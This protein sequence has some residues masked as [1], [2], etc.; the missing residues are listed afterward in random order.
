[1]TMTKHQPFIWL[2]LCL[3]LTTLACSL[4]PAGDSPSTGDNRPVLGEDRPAIVF[5]A[6]QMGNKY[7]AGSQILLHAE[8]RDLGAGVARIEFYDNFDTLIETVTAE[9]PAGQPV[10]TAIVP[11]QSTMSQVHFLK[12]RAFRADGTQSNLQEISIEIVALESFAAS[13][14]TA[15]PAVTEVATADSTSAE[16][17][18]PEPAASAETPAVSGDPL[19]VRLNATVNGA[20]TLN[21]RSGAAVSASVLQTVRR[22]AQL[23]LVGRS[24]DNQWYATPLANGSY[25]WV[26]GQY[27]QIEGDPTTLPL[28]TSQ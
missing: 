12:A 22:G 21:V 19:Q 13:E 26:F 2:V 17:T 11:W 1:M 6:P 28:V 14:T 8:A 25:G 18:T 7:A 10:L 20:E 9:N 15:E 3:I 24:A 23:E 27:L 16:S 4:S 5:L